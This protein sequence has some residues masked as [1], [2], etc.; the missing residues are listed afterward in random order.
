MTSDRES[1]RMAAGMLSSGDGSVVLAYLRS[2]RGCWVSRKTRDATNI[3]LTHTFLDG[4]CTGKLCVP[5][6]QMDGFY[7]AVGKDVSRGTMPPL[8]ELRTDVFNFFADFDMRVPAASNVTSC[9][10]GAVLAREVSRFLP[11][12]ETIRTL[13]CS[14]PDRALEDGKTK[15]GVHVYCPGVH[16]TPHEAL[17]MREAIVVAL[18]R[19]FPSIDWVEDYDNTPYVNAVGGLRMLGAPKVKKC[20]TCRDA[21]K[22]RAECVECLGS[23]H[24]VDRTQIYSLEAC[25]DRH[26]AVDHATCRVLQGN[27]M[28]LARA[29]SVRT[30]DVAISPD[31][32]CFDGC[33]SYTEMK[34]RKN[35]PPLPGSKKRAFPEESASMRKWPKVAVTNSAKLECLRNIFRTRFHSTYKNVDISHVNYAAKTGTYFAQFCNEGESFC[36]N[37]DGR[38]RSNRVYGVVQ[39]NMAFIRCHC[40]CATTEGRRTG[41]RCRDYCSTKKEITGDAVRVLGIAPENPLPASKSAPITGD[42]FLRNMSQTLKWANSMH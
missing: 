26:G 4:M 22:E 6:L 33:P 18:A 38:H 39:N 25:L 20:G 34:T 16:V 28:A 12:R 23:G 36:M 19:D 29:A 10:V 32:E 9:G 37:I 1:T 7:E 30:D 5:P 2:N 21:P 35:G 13:V 42:D 27:P 31:W 41:V 15:R 40:N 3:T 11:T 17:T 14:T 8:N 24:D